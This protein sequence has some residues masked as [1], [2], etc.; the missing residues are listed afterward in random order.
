MTGGF[1]IGEHFLVETASEWYIHIDDI[2][3][4]FFFIVLHMQFFMYILSNVQYSQLN[5][6]GNQKRVTDKIHFDIIFIILLIYL[7]HMYL[8]IYNIQN[9]GGFECNWYIV[10]YK[11]QVN[12]TFLSVLG[13]E[14]CVAYGRQVI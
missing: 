2:C 10:T 5:N 8:L 7:L 13:G 11:S 14:F 1:W 12:G 9:E 6:I 3:L 4:W